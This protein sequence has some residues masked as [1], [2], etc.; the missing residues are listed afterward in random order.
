MA[1]SIRPYRDDDAEA[2]AE[3]IAAAI[4]AIGPHA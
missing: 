4:A 3:A 2:L 1:Y